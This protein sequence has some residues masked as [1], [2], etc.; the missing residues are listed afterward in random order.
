MMK[1]YFIGGNHLLPSGWYVDT[2][3]GAEDDLIKARQRGEAAASGS[4]FTWVEASPTAWVLYSDEGY[5]G[6]T[7]YDRKG[8]ES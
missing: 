6:I 1:R 8:N 4:E 2:V 7:I 5:T 3:I